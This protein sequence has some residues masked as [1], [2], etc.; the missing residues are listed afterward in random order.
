[1]YRVSVCND[2]ESEMTLIRH[3]QVINI[4]VHRYLPVTAGPYY[5]TAS[6]TQFLRFELRFLRATYVC[7]V[8]RLSSDY[9]TIVPLFTSLTVLS[10]LLRDTQNNTP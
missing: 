4:F 2:D 1:M 10:T 7:Y 5:R 9:N 6:R 8:W 3:C